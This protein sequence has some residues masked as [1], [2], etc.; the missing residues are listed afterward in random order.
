M[1]KEQTTVLA[2]IKWGG[3]HRTSTLNFTEEAAYQVVPS[4]F[5]E[6]GATSEA[7]RQDQAVN[8]LVQKFLTQVKT[9]P[10]PTKST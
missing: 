6:Y 9:A 3:A 4:L 5:K 8:R 1:A 2:T 7:L 10:R